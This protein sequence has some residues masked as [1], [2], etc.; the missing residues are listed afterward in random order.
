MILVEFFAVWIVV[1]V[2]VSTQFFGERGGILRIR[3]MD[4][5]AA[6]VLLGPV[7]LAFG[8]IDYLDHLFWRK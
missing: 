2:L 5:F 3:G 6:I 4:D 7:I 8:I 1:G